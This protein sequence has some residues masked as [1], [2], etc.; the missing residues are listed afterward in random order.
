MGFVMGHKKYRGRRAAAFIFDL[1]GTLI[2]S[3]LDIALSANFV[4]VHFALPEIPVDTVR[5]FIGDGV[6]VLLQ[7]VLGYDIPSGQVLPV[8]EED[9]AAEAL[10]VF[11]DH[12]GR[13]CLDNTRAYPGVLEVLRRYSGLP[14]MVATNKPRRF[15]DQ[16]LQGLHLQDAFR[17]VVGG[18]D[19]AHKKP[20]PDAL[21]ACLDGLDVPVAEVVVV[22]D[23]VN[24]IESARAI[25]AMA[26]AATYGLTGAGLL[27]SAE[28]DLMIDS[29]SQLADRFPSR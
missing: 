2:D 17:K 18:D 14:L 20:A 5:G 13:H 26:V 24:D 12:Y 9:R 19:V 27:A 15:T 21:L 25:G 8:V 11:R 10:T 28:P 4:R 23:S 1:D 7:R 6:V 16:I 22:G 29:I 3:A